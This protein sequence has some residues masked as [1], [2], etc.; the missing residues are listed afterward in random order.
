MARTKQNQRPASTITASTRG[1][2]PPSKVTVALLS[3]SALAAVWSVGMLT[4]VG[5][6]AYV[7]LFFYAEFY[8]GVLTLVTLSLTVIGGVLATDRMV[9][10]IPHR[11]LLQSAHRTTGIMAVLS[12]VLHITTQISMGTVTALDVLVPFLAVDRVAFIGMGT[13]ASYL[14][15]STFWIGI[16][17]VR[18]AG[19]GRPWMWRALHSTAYVSWPVALV[20]GLNTGRPPATW[21]TLSYIGC[22]LLVVIALLVRLSVNLN[23]KK[24]WAAT[25]TGSM[26]PVGKPASGESTGKATAARPRRRPPIR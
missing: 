2:N 6:V 8:A 16:V 20:H 19:R 4:P 7:Y 14:L 11:V 22:V 25:G 21:V 9:L 1:G 3:I 23:R 17:R 26:K 5:R 24:A 15:L 13:I 18:F 12:L 10:Q